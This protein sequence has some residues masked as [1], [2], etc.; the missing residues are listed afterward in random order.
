M[1][2]PSFSGVSAPDDSGVVAVEPPEGRL[3][4]D[5]APDM[6]VPVTHS[7]TRHHGDSKPGVPITPQ[8]D[9]KPGVPITPHGD[10]KPGVPFTRHVGIGKGFGGVWVCGCVCRGGVVR[11]G[12]RT[13]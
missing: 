5:G 10:S 13:N 7:N 8:G 2:W 3:P 12:L 4:G 11:G 1:D 6:G 9:S